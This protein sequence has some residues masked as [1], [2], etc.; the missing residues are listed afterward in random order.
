[1]VEDPVSNRSDVL[2]HMKYRREQ[3]I[4]DKVLEIYICNQGSYYE[5]EIVGKEVISSLEVSV[6]I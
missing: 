6:L 5:K 3:L 1:M 2:E 4:T